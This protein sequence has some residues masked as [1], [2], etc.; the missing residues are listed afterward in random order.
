MRPPLGNEPFGLPV[1]RMADIARQQKDG[2]AQRQLQAISEWIASFGVEASGISI[3][4][5]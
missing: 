4:L 3:T 5:D 1:G 2:N